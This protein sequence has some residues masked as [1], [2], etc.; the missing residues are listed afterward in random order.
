MRRALLGIFAVLCLVLGAYG[1]WTYGTRDSDWSALSSA[2]LRAGVLLA[3]LWLALP[4]LE[5]L[6]RVCPP[7]MLGVAAAC[8]VA[9]V[10]RPRLLVYLLPL[11]GV[12]LV[13]RFFGWLLQPLPMK[14][15]PSRASAASRSEP[16]N[17]KRDS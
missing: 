6:L 3:S 7:W 8:G 15:K 4:Q 13:L 17:A 16:T 2:G 11:L 12:L 14:T 10:V 1:V 9:V 5:R